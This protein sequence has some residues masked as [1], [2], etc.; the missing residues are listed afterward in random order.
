MKKLMCT[1]AVAAAL[2]LACAGAQAATYDFTTEFSG[3]TAPGTG[4]YATI[5]Y[6]D[7]VGGVL[8]NLTLLSN[9]IDWNAKSL[10]INYAGGAALTPASFT[11]V[12]GE[13][14]T[15]IQVGSDSFKADGD[16]YFDILLNYPNG[17]GFNQGES[18]Q[19]QIAG[20]AA[21]SFDATSAPGGGNGTWY[22]AI[23]AQNTS[24]EGASGWLGAVPGGTVSEPGSLA[25]LLAGL[26][27]LGLGFVARRRKEA[28]AA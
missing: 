14:A 28:S 15:S 25:T 26:G 12:S 8:M 23:H 3:G 10:Y 4:P 27:L 2:A 7:T 20:A 5:S 9:S 16:G 19:Y 6:T 22:A 11:L 1:S 24:A 17:G 18:S 21:S 13:A